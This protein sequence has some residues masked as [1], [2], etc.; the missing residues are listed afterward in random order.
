M[1]GFSVNWLSDSKVKRRWIWMTTWAVEH[2]TSLHVPATTRWTLEATDTVMPGS[3]LRWGFVARPSFTPWTSSYRASSSL[4]SA[5]VSSTSPPTPVKKWPCASQSSSLWWSSCFS[6]QRF[7]R[8]RPSTFRWS[9]STCSSRFLPKEFSSGIFW[10]ATAFNKR[11]A[12]L[13]FLRYSSL[14][15]NIPTCAVVDTVYQWC[16]FITFLAKR[17]LFWNL[18]VSYCFQQKN[19][20]HAFSRIFLFISELIPTCGV[21][22]TVC[23]WCL[24]ITF[25]AKTVLLWFF[26]P[27]EFLSNL[28]FSSAS[29][30]SGVP[31][32]LWRGFMFHVSCQN[33]YLMEY[34]VVIGSSC[35]LKNF[36]QSFFSTAFA[37]RRFP[38]WCV[39]HGMI[40][41]VHV[42][43]VCLRQRIICDVVWTQV[44]CR[45]HLDVLRLKLLPW[46]IFP[47]VEQ[48]IGTI[49]FLSW[50]LLFT[51]CDTFSAHC[52]HVVGRVFCTQICGGNQWIQYPRGR[53]RN[54][55]L[56]SKQDLWTVVVPAFHVLWPSR[57][58][59]YHVV[60]YVFCTQIWCVGNQ[61]IQYLEE[62]F[63][64]SLWPAGK[65]CGQW[66]LLFTFLMNILTIVL[67][68]AITNRNF[69]TP[70]THTMPRWVRTVFLDVLPRIL[71]MRRPY[72]EARCASVKTYN[73]RNYRSASPTTRL[74]CTLAPRLSFTRQRP[75]TGGGSVFEMSSMGQDCDERSSCSHRSQFCSLTHLVFGT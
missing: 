57:A 36:C 66:Y 46:D 62:E 60:G 27:K 7:F 32:P 20:C 1:N 33:G 24:F 9:P 12:V 69:R 56:T 28:F 39:W 42:S 14:Y 73:R 16:L 4:S 71:L 3:R 67:A 68:V 59:C 10:L 2:G 50:Y 65:V 6:S 61:R 17:V 37:V 70:R 72:H 64:T 8:R 40:P 58:H 54:V 11:I 48:G 5:S 44:P 13:P 15:R 49:I 47:D 21:V 18:L 55:T 26:L 53:V 51:F 23:Q 34:V 41:A 29:L 74:S 30:V 25:L 38:S 22:D 45:L 52:Y 31:P 19:C 43:S 63:L 75:S 35:C